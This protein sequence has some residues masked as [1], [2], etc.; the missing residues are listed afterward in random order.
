LLTSVRWRW[1]FQG[2][3]RSWAACGKA[4]SKSVRQGR[5]R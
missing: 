3:S 2:C 5:R 4:A 1:A